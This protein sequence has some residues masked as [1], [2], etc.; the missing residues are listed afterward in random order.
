MRR[1]RRLKL[2]HVG[3]HQLAGELSKGRDL[4]HK[5]IRVEAIHLRRRRSPPIRAH[6]THDRKARL[7]DSIRKPAQAIPRTLRLA[8]LTG[9][10]G[11]ANEHAFQVIVF[12]CL[13]RERNHLVVRRYVEIVK[14][15]A[16][17]RLDRVAV[18]DVLDLSEMLHADY[19]HDLVFVAGILREPVL[20][21]E[22]AFAAGH[23]V[24]VIHEEHQRARALA[25]R[26]V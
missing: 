13:V 5:L 17:A 10:G 12:D 18:F 4:S 22:C 23:E 19:R 21:G 3:D 20:G 16:A 14:I 9:S 6:R 15:R 1:L 8:V 11:C 25:P 26:D 24:T 7:V 2:L